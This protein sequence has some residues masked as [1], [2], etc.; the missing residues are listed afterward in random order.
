VLEW[1][2]RSRKRLPG[3]TRTAPRG[4]PHQAADD[5]SR[6]GSPSHR[7]GRRDPLRGSE[8]RGRPSTPVG[9]RTT[10]NVVPA[11]HRRFG[12][13]GGR[14]SAC[15][16]EADRGNGQEDRQVAG[17][18]TA[19]R[20][21]GHSAVGCGDRRHGAACHL[22]DSAVG[23]AAAVGI[24]PRLDRGPRGGRVQAARAGARRPDTGPEG[25]RVREPGRREQDDLGSDQPDCHCPA[26]GTVPR[27]A[28]LDQDASPPFCRRLYHWVCGSATIW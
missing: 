17:G 16:A 20:G 7:S 28:R 4:P 10:C 5:P 15:G 6:Y 27:A 1:P 19:E 24:S 18:V 14:R 3:D 21:E 26:D 22:A 9:H 13:S 11:D 12:K 23:A 2:R 25:V 8:V